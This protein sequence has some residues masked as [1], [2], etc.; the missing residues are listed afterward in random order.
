MKIVKCGTK[1]QERY[2]VVRYGHDLY[3]VRYKGGHT[4]DTFSGL[5]AAERAQADCD[6]LNAMQD[7]PKAGDV[8]RSN[9][10]GEYYLVAHGG[11][12]AIG[13]TGAFADTLVG[14]PIDC[15][16]LGPIRTIICGDGEVER[17]W[18]VQQAATCRYLVDGEV[19]VLQIHNGQLAQR[20]A[21]A[22]NLLD[23]VEGA[24]DG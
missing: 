2:D 23:A 7:E 1:K 9:V 18:S 21:R 15:I 14:T 4:V 22:L 12:K 20:I 10:S 6:W 5:G 3:R 16:N 19:R 17:R 24:N 13:L 11:T 8:L